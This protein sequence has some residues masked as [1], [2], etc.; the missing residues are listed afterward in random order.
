[1]PGVDATVSAELL[2]DDPNKVLDALSILTQAGNESTKRVNKK[3][4]KERKSAMKSVTSW[5]LEGNPPEEDPVC[6]QGGEAQLTSFGELRM[7]DAL[8]AVLRGGVHSCLRVY[9]VTR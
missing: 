5:V 9:P 8:R 2:C 6:L 1:M 4:R 7:M 3:E